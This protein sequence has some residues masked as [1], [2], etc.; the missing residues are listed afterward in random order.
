[1][2]YV[3]YGNNTNQE[4]INMKAL[5][6]RS[7]TAIIALFILINVSYTE[8]SAQSDTEKEVIAVI[9]AFHSALA[10]GDSIT[11]LDYLAEDV[12]ILESGGIENKHHYASGH[13]SGDMRFAKAV[14]R[15]RG[16]ITVSIVGDVAWAYASS[17]TQGKMGDREVNSMGAELVVL[18]RHDNTWIIKAIHWSS[19]RK[20]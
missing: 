7:Y 12:T 6:K 13:I 15:K 14:P 18:A 20:K 3:Y 5:I 4:T 9:D 16:D 19:R 2:V 8:V 1:M 17:I 10:S 11:A